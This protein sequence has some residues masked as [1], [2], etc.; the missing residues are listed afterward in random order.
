M[1]ALGPWGV[2]CLR[3]VKLA[4]VL[5]VSDTGVRALAKATVSD[6]VKARIENGDKDLDLKDWRSGGNLVVVDCV[7]PFNSADMFVDKFLA[8]INQDQDTGFVAQ[9]A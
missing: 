9:M 4:F 5:P 1:S 2:L 8:S 7:S 3:P 6:E